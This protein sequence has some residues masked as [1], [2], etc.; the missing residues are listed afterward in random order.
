MFLYIY[1]NHNYCQLA[2]ESI[3]CN[4][5]ILNFEICCAF[6]VSGVF[7]RLA[8]VLK[9]ECLT[10]FSHSV[11]EIYVIPEVITGEAICRQE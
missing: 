7:I 3:T 9:F 2:N 4:T 10:V 5:F 1:T 6:G 8:T 11:I